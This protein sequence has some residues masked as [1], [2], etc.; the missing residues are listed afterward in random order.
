MTWEEDYL[1]ANAGSPVDGTWYEVTNYSG[2]GILMGVGQSNDTT[3]TGELRI[4]ADSNAHTI[5]KASLE[6]VRDMFTGTNND[7]GHIPMCL[8]FNATLV[9]EIRR[10]GDTNALRGWAH[11]GILSEE[12]KREIIPAGDPLPMRDYTYPY[13]VMV[14]HFCEKVVDGQPNGHLS[15]KIQFPQSEII[16]VGAGQVQEVAFNTTV[17]GPRYDYA[18]S[19]FTGTKQITVEDEVFD[20]PITNGIITPDSIPFMI[21][22]K[23]FWG[24]FTS[25]EQE[26]L[27]AHTNKKVKALLYEIRMRPKINLRWSKLI[28]AINAMENA[29]IIG[30]GRAA[31]IL[32][33]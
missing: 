7:D 15:S 28:T 30:A 11:Y 8:E 3:Q 4:T 23:A 27:V 21:T 13:D 25:A 26:T 17:K 10:D 5:V 20:L 32:A 29:G 9:V 31:E 2:Q 1:N 22:N 12:Y 14:I 19:N 18:Q 33:V 24:R 6:I 16:N